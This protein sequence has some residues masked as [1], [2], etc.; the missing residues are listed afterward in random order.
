[1]TDSCLSVD[2]LTT[3][4]FVLFMA[5][6]RDMNYYCYHYT[7]NNIISIIFY[8]VRLKNIYKLIDIT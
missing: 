7:T 8:S 6:V 2:F 1:M 4:I 5:G 3:Q